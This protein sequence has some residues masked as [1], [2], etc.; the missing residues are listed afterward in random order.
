MFQKK[1]ESEYRV[2]AKKTDPSLSPSDSLT[3]GEKGEKIV[4]EE[5]AFICLFKTAFFKGK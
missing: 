5:A 3:H 2:T 1:T 4:P